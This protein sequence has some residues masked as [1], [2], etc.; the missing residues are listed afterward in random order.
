MMYISAKKSLLSNISD[1]NSIEV[2]SGSVYTAIA[3]SNQAIEAGQLYSLVV[4][5]EESPTGATRCLC[6]FQTPWLYREDGS[7]YYDAFVGLPEGENKINVMFPSSADA[8]SKF[9]VWTNNLTGTLIFNN[10]QLYKL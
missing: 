5:I 2:G 4:N 3:I 9:Y 1:F 6:G 10:L 7:S 8:G